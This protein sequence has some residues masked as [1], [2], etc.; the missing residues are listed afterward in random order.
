[1]ESF[2]VSKQFWSYLQT[3][4][5]FPNTDFIQ[6]TPHCSFVIGE[7]DVDFLAHRHQAMIQSPLFDSMLYSQ[8][9]IVISQ[10]MPLIMQGRDPS[11]PVAATYSTL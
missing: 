5:Y 4:Q 10:R 7:K 9:P 8:D 3:Q 6:S 11:Q 1:M 2:E